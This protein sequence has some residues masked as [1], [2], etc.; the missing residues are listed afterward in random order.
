MT[1]S[2]LQRMTKRAASRFA[3]LPA[4][5]GWRDHAIGLGLS[6]AYFVW[7][8]V[9]ARSLGFPRDE[10]LYFRAGSAYALWWRSLFEHG[11]DALKQNAIDAAWSINH[12]HPALMK[13]LFGL[14]CWLFHEKWHVVSDASTAYRLPAMAMAAITVWTTYLF[15]A[16]AW[17][18]RAGGAGALLFALMPRVFF[19]SHLACFDVPITAMWIVC[20]Y[21]HWRAQERRRLWWAIATGLV[22]GLALETKHNAW[23]LP[24]ALVPHALFVHRRAIWRGLRAGR[25]SLPSSLVSMAVVGPV[26]FYA[27]WPYLWNDTIERLQWYVNFHLNHEYY[28]LEFLGKNYFGPPSPK[29]YLPV[30]VL[31]TVP[32]VTLVLF[33]VG[34]VER[35][36]IATGRARAWVT[37]RLGKQTDAQ[38]RW[39][40]APRDPR[41]TDLLLAL[42]LV[43]A[44]GPFFLP[45]TPIFGGTKHW[46]PAYPVLALLAGRGFDRAVAAMRQAMPVRFGASAWRS[47]LFEVGL[48]ASVVVGPLAI[49]IHSHPFGLSTYVPLVGGTAGGA[50]LG[51]NRQ[52]WGYTSQSAAE[53]YLNASAPR[54]ATVFIHDTTWDAWARMQEEGRVRSDLRAVG[55][56]AE[57][58]IALVEHE[59]HMN[60]VDYSIWVADGTDAPVY[61]VRHDGVPI[62][63]VYE[64]R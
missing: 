57:A 11:Q 50:D 42:S 37:H 44:I 13:T 15:G 9:T 17:S 2:S 36:T 33:A 4:A 61:V 12:E 3:S 5:V 10:A 48:L 26:V 25:V 40:S 34:A 64:R 24:A 14:S 16:R 46:L 29:S 7:L 39:P 62:V 8:F 35:A 30:M 20:L 38:S 51:L 41:A 56:P 58:A 31:A 47:R 19:H 45:K 23:M 49:T 27:L 1:F 32:A 6:T 52:F 18:R 59:L 22:F 55:T 43:V 63:S 28:N 60:E 54:A 53:E 21:V